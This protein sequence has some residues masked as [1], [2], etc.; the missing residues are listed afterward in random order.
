MNLAAQLRAASA[1]ATHS[2]DKYISK[3]STSRD[4]DSRANLQSKNRDGI[5][6]HSSSLSNEKTL[7]E[8]MN[9][10]FKGLIAWFICMAMGYS[11]QS[12]ADIKSDVS[13]KNSE[14]F[15][16]LMH[17]MGFSV[18]LL[19]FTGQI[20]W[21][22]INGTVGL[23]MLWIFNE[24]GLDNRWAVIST[25]SVGYLIIAVVVVSAILVFGGVVLV[26][27][28]LLEFV[29]N[30]LTRYPEV[31]DDLRQE[32]VLEQVL[33]RYLSNV[34]KTTVLRP[35][36]NAFADEHEL[37]ASDEEA[38]LDNN[39]VHVHGNSQLLEHPSNHRKCLPLM[40]NNESDCSLNYLRRYKGDHGSYNS[41]RDKLSNS[42]SVSPRKLNDDIDVQVEAEVSNK[43]LMAVLHGQKSNS[44][45]FCLK[46]N[47]SFL[48]PACS[49]WKPRDQ[50]GSNGEVSG[51]SM[52]TPVC[53][54]I[55][56]CL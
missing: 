25:H 9:M 18:F 49:G 21:L 14:A 10:F 39:L 3:H 29:K 55:F 13:T 24:S 20:R 35:T 12:V 48:L 15:A 34:P 11:F 31:Q 46:T 52:C 42:A 33:L 19:Y 37:Y 38:G 6:V 43:K 54:L 28:H 40:N 30:I 1:E 56:V 50:H 8:R 47:P 36:V 23:I 22:I 26:W 5:D 53:I 45:F 41:L 32:K 27:S 51:I 17:S 2:Y 7:A 16:L 44:C 4:R